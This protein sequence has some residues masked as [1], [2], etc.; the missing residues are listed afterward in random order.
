MWEADGVADFAWRVRVGDIDDANAVPVPSVEN[1]ILENR[2]F[3]I[4]L[5]N[6]PSRLPVRLGDRLI[7]AVVESVVGYRERPDQGRH[8]LRL[9]RQDARIVERAPAVLVGD[10]DVR[11]PV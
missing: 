5:C 11:R 2:G 7:E 1:E 8:N 10:P 4:L 9:D 3:V 6:E